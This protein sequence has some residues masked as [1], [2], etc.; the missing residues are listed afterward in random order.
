MTN[1][2]A[3]RINAV[4]SFWFGPN[5][6]TARSQWFKTDPAFD[7][8]ITVLFG[9]DYERA[10]AGAL[11]SWEDSAQGALALTILLDQFSRNMFR[12]TVRAFE[13]D[14][15][16]LRVAKDAIARGFDQQVTPVQRVFFYLPFEHS[17][18]LADQERSLA[19]VGALNDARTKDY[20]EQHA[21]II[22]RFGRFPH[23]NAVLGRQSTPEEIAYLKDS[24]PSFA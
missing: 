14:A 7:R 9:A 21:A 4:L 1:S 11:I 24:P 10:R 19:L 8:A 15:L 2:P 13:S 6:E 20:A 17:E 12:K 18:N 5:P 23:R 22:R 3:P 16:A